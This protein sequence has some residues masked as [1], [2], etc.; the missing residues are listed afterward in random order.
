LGFKENLAKAM[1]VVLS[2]KWSTFLKYYTHNAS[3]RMFECSDYVITVSEVEYVTTRSYLIA[4]HAIRGCIFT[5]FIHL[6]DTT[7]NS[8]EINCKFY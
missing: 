4:E 2:L 3:A 6:V 5:F 1:S 8:C 7:N